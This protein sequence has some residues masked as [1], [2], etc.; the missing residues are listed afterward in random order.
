MMN[1][2][3]VCLTVA[4]VALSGSFAFAQQAQKT[5]IGK[6]EYEAKCAVCHGAG[7]K[8]DGPMAGQLRTRP[9]DLT[10][11][12]SKN[13]GVVPVARMFEVIEGANVPAHGTREMPVWGREFRIEDAQYLK[14]AR[15]RYDAA[16][17]VRARILALI[18][19]LNRIQAR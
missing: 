10:M 19:Y 16:A 17:L 1:M 5:D 3:K 9:S 4:G 15:G 6:L 8:G 2:T 7:G 18:D 14:E 12:A 11:L 13:Q